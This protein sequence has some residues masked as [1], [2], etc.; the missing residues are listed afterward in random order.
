MRNPHLL[1]RVARCLGWTKE[2]RPENSP[3]EIIVGRVKEKGPQDSRTLKI[4]I[5]E[6]E[7]E[8][9]NLLAWIGYR[10]GQEVEL[11]RTRV[12]DVVYDY[13]GVD[14]SKKV[15]VSRN[16]ERT[17]ISISPPTQQPAY[18]YFAY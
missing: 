7:R 10:V 16:L 8:Y 9:K 5:G 11:H 3:I 12:Y 4:K 13:V 1:R 6:E 15:E 14:F 2:I 18:R 17:D